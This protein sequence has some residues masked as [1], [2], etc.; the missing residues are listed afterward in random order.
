MY[1]VSHDILKYICDNLNIFVIIWI[2][3]VTLGSGHIWRF[4]NHAPKFFVHFVPYATIPFMGLRICNR[5][6][7]LSICFV[8]NTRI[9]KAMRTFPISI[10][11]IA[12]LYQ[13]SA[14]TRCFCFLF[15]LVFWFC[16][17][18][19]KL[20]ICF[21]FN[22]WIT[23][24]MRTFP[25]SII[26]IAILYQWSAWTRCFCFFVCSCILILV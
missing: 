16:N 1:L 26:N 11:N 19:P 10:I 14:W 6:P 8:F 23:K 2:C 3:I 22:T 5:P 18:P 17:R 15:A 7:K 25:I 12:I 24:A 20:S 4:C 21:V 9:T 13:W